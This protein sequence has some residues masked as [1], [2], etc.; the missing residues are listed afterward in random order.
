MTVLGQA[1]LGIWMDIVPGVE[2]DF[3]RWYR[4]Q[5]FPER[6]GVPGFLRGRRYRTVREAPTFFTLYETENADVLR[7]A[8]YMTCLNN[9]TDWTRRVLPNMRNVV[10]NAYRLIHTVGIGMGQ[11]VITLR[12]DPL[13]GREDQLRRR[14]QGEVLAGLTR[15]P[16]V[17]SAS[18]FEA[19]PV[20]TG[21]IT[22]ERKLVGTM[23]TASPFLCICE[24]REPDVIDHPAWRALA[25]PEGPARQDIVHGFTENPYR[26]IHALQ[27]PPA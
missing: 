10:R 23:G 27:R 1:A 9:P 7:S 25:G 24:V 3:E 17:L 6:L 12:L 2:D 15:V 21:V 8:A 19:E 16:D 26:L 13:P 14:Y 5:H 11:A 20:A 4:E 18:L 22:E